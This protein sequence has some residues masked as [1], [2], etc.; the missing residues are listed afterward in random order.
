MANSKSIPRLELRKITKSY[1]TVVANDA[2]SLTVAPG[3]IHAVLGENGAGKST[4]MKVI[5]GVARP[6]AGTILWEGKPEVVGS[7]AYARRLGIGMVFQHFSVFPALTVLENILLLS[8]KGTRRQELA[9]RISELSQEYGLPVNPDAT[10]GML[11]VGERQRVE[12]VRCLLQEP[13]LLILDEPTSVLT[14]QAIQ[15]LFVMLT[16]LADAGHS[17]LYI[18]HKLHEIRQLCDTAT[19]LRHGKVVATV[20][21]RQETD[22]SLAHH[23]LGTLVPSLSKGTSAESG[24]QRLIVESL[25]RRAE[26]VHGVDLE[27]INLTV[28]GGEILGIAGITGNGQAEL[29]EAVSGEWQSPSARNVCIDGTAAA[30]L[31]VTRRR[32]LGLVYIPEERLGQGSVPGM[33]LVKNGLLTV[34]VGKFVRWGVIRMDAVRQFASKCIEE[35]DVRPA[36]YAISAEALS[37]GN[38][39]KFI[40]GRELLQAPGVVVAAQPTWG[41]DVGAAQSIRQ[42]LLKLRASGVAILVISE[43]LDELLELCDRIAVMA[44]GRIS[45]AR[46]V[47]ETSIAEIGRLMSGEHEPVPA[48][49][50]GA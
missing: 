36:T 45:E 32:R 40:V 14:P 42:I 49:A 41:L 4:L 38:L 27:N 8:P 48:N 22:A 47:G 6:D 30:R 1:P 10:V 35:F 25:S 46:A 12:I 39:Q 5:Y 16:R 15:E 17:I 3:S 2:V 31:G 43:D 28:F 9:A 23:M 19:I 7:P 26:T 50:A 29:L 33:S 44:N 18:S 11:S 34:Q 24:A 20:D 13:K 37:G 21:P